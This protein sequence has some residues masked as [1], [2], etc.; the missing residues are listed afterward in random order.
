[1]VRKGRPAVV[2]KRPASVK[3][4]MPSIEELSARHHD[5][6]IGVLDGEVLGCKALRRMLEQEHG[7]TAADDSMKRWKAMLLEGCPAMV[8]KRPASEADSTLTYAG[9]WR[10]DVWGRAQVAVYRRR[11]NAQ[12][13]GFAES[14]GCKALAAECRLTAPYGFGWWAIWRKRR[15]DPMCVVLNLKVEFFMAC[16]DFMTLVWNLLF[17]KTPTAFFITIIFIIIS[18]SSNSSV[19]IEALRQQRSRQL[20]PRRRARGE[21]SIPFA[22][23]GSLRWGTAHNGAA[24]EKLAGGLLVPPRID[25]ACSP[26]RVFR[27]VLGGEGEE[28]G[29][30]R[31]GEDEGQRAR[32]AQPQGPR[33]DGGGASALTAG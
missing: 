32:D 33:P 28:A 8:R 13:V 23:A 29:G 1:M 10:H 3:L 2:R 7:V 18:S 14:L 5:W 22:P 17:L 12:N 24:N 27:E 15:L 6:G 20:L 21:A 19:A 11:L 16:L 9:L 4:E 30:G 26:V 31:E 25:A